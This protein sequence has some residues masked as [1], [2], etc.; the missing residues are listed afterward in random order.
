M[1]VISKRMLREFWE[2]HPD[3]KEQLKAW[4]NEAERAAW[5]SPEDIKKEFPS[6]SVL[7][8]KR[9]IFNIKGNAYRIVVRINY[10][11]GVV[12]IRFV[13]N[14]EEYSKIDAKEI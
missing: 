1:R 10:D 9:V 12:W 3:C 8:S 6:A 11:Y 7:K 13:G 4:Y 2:R 14:H 5:Q